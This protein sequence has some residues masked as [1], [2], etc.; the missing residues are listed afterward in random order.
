MSSFPLLDATFKE[1]LRFH[2][3]ATLSFRTAQR[4]FTTPH[5]NIRKGDVVILKFNAVHRNPAVFRNPDEFRPERFLG[6]EKGHSDAFLFAFGSG[7]RACIG[8]NLAYIEARMALS[9]LL[10]HFDVTVHSDMDLV[11]GI[12]VYP[13]DRLPVTLA[14]RSSEATLK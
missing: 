13:K 9:Y 5:G 6:D 10:H 11:Q 3:P 8:R 4:D 2:T 7:P 14:M 1:N 12:T